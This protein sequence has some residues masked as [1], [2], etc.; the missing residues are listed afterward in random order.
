MITYRD[1][2]RYNESVMLMVCSSCGSQISEAAVKCPKCGHPNQVHESRNRL[3][4]G[5][6]MFGLG[7]LMCGAAIFLLIADSNSRGM[8]IYPERL[9]PTSANVGPMQLLFTPGLLLILFGL[10]RTL[11]SLA[12]RSH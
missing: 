7:I 4:S 8:S 1:H 10:G 12:K 11:V 2:F 9:F 6:T 3:R 5:L